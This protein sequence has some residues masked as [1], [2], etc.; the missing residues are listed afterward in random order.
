MVYVLLVVSVKSTLEEVYESVN[1]EVIAAYRNQHFSV[2]GEEYIV[3]LSV[4]IPL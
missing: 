3:W 2:R 4:N 1:R